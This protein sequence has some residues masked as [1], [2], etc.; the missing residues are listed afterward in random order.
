MSARETLRTIAAWVTLPAPPEPCAAAEYAAA[1]RALADRMDAEMAEVEA[2]PGRADGR[3]TT[4][5]AR[6]ADCLY[7]LDAPLDQP[8]PHGH[9][10]EDCCWKGTPP[11]PVPT[12]CARCLSPF[13]PMCDHGLCPQCVAADPCRQLR[14]P[15]TPGER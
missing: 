13:G 8:C 3:K 11:A 12:V 9:R 15:A 2:M 1:L 4:A 6:V 14:G 7:R 5:N 10:Y